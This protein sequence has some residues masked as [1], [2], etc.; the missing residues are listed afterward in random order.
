MFI[1]KEFKE[2]KK[3]SKRIQKKTAS[4]GPEPKIAVHQRFKK[5]KTNP[6]LNEE[7]SKII[8]DDK[9]SRSEFYRFKNHENDFLSS[10]QS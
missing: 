4:R 7:K 9:K 6:V 2:S 5:P 1:S 8:I 10:K 3:G